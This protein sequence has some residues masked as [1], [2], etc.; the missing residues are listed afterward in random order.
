MAV[1]TRLRP[2]KFEARDNRV[3]IATLIREPSDEALFRWLEGS[4]QTTLDVID[5]ENINAP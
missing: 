5:F 3:C 1:Q 4:K 2:V